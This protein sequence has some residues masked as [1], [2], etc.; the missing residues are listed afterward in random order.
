MTPTMN[1]SVKEPEITKEITEGSHNTNNEQLC[2]EEPVIAE[3]ISEELL[4]KN[5]KT[6]A[7][8]GENYVIYWYSEQTQLKNW[9][10]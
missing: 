5:H 7:S 1:T 10:F 9:Q 8:E 2:V 4:S 6:A 3:V